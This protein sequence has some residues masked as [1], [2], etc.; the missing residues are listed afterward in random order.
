MH[1]SKKISKIVLVLSLVTVFS[2]LTIVSI[3]GENFQTEQ[4]KID[5]II[6]YWKPSA[7]IK[8]L[9]KRS[10]RY[11]TP[12]EGA[13]LF[14]STIGDDDETKPIKKFISFATLLEQKISKN[15]N[16]A[17]YF[18][19][20]DINPQFINNFKEVRNPNFNNRSILTN[21]IGGKKYYHVDFATNKK[22]TETEKTFSQ[23]VDNAKLLGTKAYLSLDLDDTDSDVKFI[24]YND[25][26]LINALQDYNFRMALENFNK[27]E[28][29]LD[30]LLD[31]YAGRKI[32]V[33]ENSDSA[34]DLFN[35]RE[36]GE[37][38]IKSVTH[39]FT[40][41]NFEQRLTIIKDAFSKSDV[42]GHKS[43]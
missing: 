28:V 17:F 37:W 15:R 27:R 33:E 34:A 13:Y 43:L 38:L 20:H 19:M 3:N 9:I 40:I 18:K 4:N 5:Y 24:G 11:K 22:V 12:N 21:G 10:R 30:G 31:R 23:F 6:P 25:V 41:D 7:T 39:Y 14:Y 42:V 35:E 32:Y 26:N 1:S 36:T 2:F 8:D 29:V 16:Q